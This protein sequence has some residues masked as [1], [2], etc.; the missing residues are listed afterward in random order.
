MSISSF[1]KVEIHASLPEFGSSNTLPWLAHFGG[2]QPR[3]VAGGRTL[4]HQG[5]SPPASLLQP[6]HI[7]PPLNRDLPC[8]CQNLPTKPWLLKH[9]NH[10]DTRL[11]LQSLCF[12]VIFKKHSNRKW[13]LCAKL[14]PRPLLEGLCIGRNILIFYCHL[15]LQKDL[16]PSRLQI[17]KVL[18]IYSGALNPKRTI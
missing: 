13:I 10:E 3:V 4:S 18:L 12:G 16:R 14:H 7:W 6:A 5:R 9:R 15:S 17:S 2:R 11:S 1:K 8:T